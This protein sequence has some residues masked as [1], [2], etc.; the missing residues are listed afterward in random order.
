MFGKKQ[1]RIEELEDDLELSQDTVNRLRDELDA[2]KGKYDRLREADIHSAELAKSKLYSDSVIKLQ[3][4]CSEYEIR[5]AKLNAQLKEQKSEVYADYD[6]ILVDL[7]T[8]LAEAN[9]KIEGQ[10][11]VIANYESI[12]KFIKENQEVL[13][14]CMAEIAPKVDLSKLGINLDVPVSVHQK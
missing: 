7:Q 8:K 2:Q 5:I 3:E 9:G 13:L 11:A 6:E 12:Q 1:E 14:G 10:K 4:Q